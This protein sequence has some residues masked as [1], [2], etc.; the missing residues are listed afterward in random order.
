MIATG[1]K[2][3]LPFIRAEPYGTEKTNKVVKGVEENRDGFSL[4]YCPDK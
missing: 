1:R 3:I 4:F 2:G